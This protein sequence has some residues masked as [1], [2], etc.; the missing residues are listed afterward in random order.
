MFIGTF[1]IIPSQILSLKMA[2]FVLSGQIFKMQNSKQVLN[3]QSVKIFIAV[4]MSAT[5]S[6]RVAILFQTVDIH[7]EVK[8]C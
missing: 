7:I 8:I 5:I 1:F 2:N 6:H 3:Y 4:C